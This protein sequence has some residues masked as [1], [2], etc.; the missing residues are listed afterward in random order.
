MQA[1]MNKEV[2]ENCMTKKLD[3]IPEYLR[4]QLG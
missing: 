3:E 4:E 1:V 2:V